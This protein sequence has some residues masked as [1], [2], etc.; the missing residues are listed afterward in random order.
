[1]DDRNTINRW[2]RQHGYTM[3]VVMDGGGRPSRYGIAAQY[4]V[5]A[6][7]TNFLLDGNGNLLWK[8]V[9]FDEDGMR[10]AIQSALEP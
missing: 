9:G 5:E 3:K 2:L 6:F 8:G 1:V 4:G 10:R 7:P